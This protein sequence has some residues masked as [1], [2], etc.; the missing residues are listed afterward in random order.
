MQLNYGMNVTSNPVHG[1]VKY[2]SK[3]RSLHSVCMKG[4]CSLCISTLQCPPLP[5]SSPQHLVN[6]HSLQTLHPSIILCAVWSWQT[7]TVRTDSE[8]KH[9]Y[10]HLAHAERQFGRVEIILTYTKPALTCFHPF[11]R[12]SYM[13]HCTNLTWERNQVSTLFLNF[14]NIKIRT[15][16]FMPIILRLFRL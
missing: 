5:C 8:V 3:H 11:C 2:P 13:W 6:K 9:I 7:E 10:H 14:N 15:Q 16:H 12:E 1:D 4:R